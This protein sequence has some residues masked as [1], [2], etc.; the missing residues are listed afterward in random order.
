MEISTLQSL[1]HKKLFPQ[2]FLEKCC[3]KF[4]T[5]DS[6][7]KFYS[8]DECELECNLKL[9]CVFWSYKPEDGTCRLD[10]I[11][12]HCSKVRTAME[13]LVFKDKDSVLLSFTKLRQFYKIAIGFEP[14]TNIW[15]QYLFIILL[16]LC[17]QQ[18]AP[19]F[20]SKEGTSA[21]QFAILISIF[22]LWLSIGN[23]IIVGFTCYRNLPKTEYWHNILMHLE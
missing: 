2:W 17:V 13:L 7:L 9:D 4:L 11:D 12:E 1:D 18:K 16:L 22:L 6:S 20:C 8:H 10:T 19:A 3:P 21:P 14:L 5:G 23:A 15:L